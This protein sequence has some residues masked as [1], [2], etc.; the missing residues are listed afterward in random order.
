MGLGSGDKVTIYDGANAEG[1]MLEE[2]TG[3]GSSGLGYVMTTAENA[4]V[5][6]DTSSSE[7]GRGFHF[8]YIIGEYVGCRRVRRL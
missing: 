5:Y 8:K 4:Y 7:V 6:M 2:Y 3:D 1:A